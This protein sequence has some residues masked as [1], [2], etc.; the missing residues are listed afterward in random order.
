MTKSQ[1]P[2][3]KVKKV[4]FLTPRK[5]S[6]EKVEKSDFFR[7]PKMGPIFDHFWP[8][9]FP[10]FIKNFWDHRIRPLNFSDLKKP[11]KNGSKNGSQK[12]TPQKNSTP[13]VPT[14]GVVF[15]IWPGSKNRSL[16]K[17]CFMPKKDKNPEKLVHFLE[18]VF[19]KMAFF[20]KIEEPGNVKSDQ[21]LLKTYI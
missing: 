6:F 7:G 10:Q 3:K 11:E 19:Q 18:N 12:M 16:F 2:P 15:R 1:K 9:N 5:S 21:K 14:Q 20:Q 4:G 13:W 17:K 8:H